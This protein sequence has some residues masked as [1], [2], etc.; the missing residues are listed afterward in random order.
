VRSP[1]KDANLIGLGKLSAWNGTWV[2]QMWRS[3]IS[4]TTMG[5]M[6]T[7]VALPAQAVVIYPWCANYSGRGMGGAQN[8]GFVSFNQCLAT[9]RGVG[10]TCGPNPTRSDRRKSESYCEVID[11]EG[12]AVAIPSH[13]VLLC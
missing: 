12:L 13:Q 6:L 5:L 4:K 8:C 9:V 1:V 11:E 7:A 10:G 2:T 3:F